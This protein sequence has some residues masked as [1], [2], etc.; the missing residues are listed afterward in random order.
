MRI[1]VLGLGNDLLAD[2]GFGLIAARSLAGDTSPGVEV[3]CSAA[4]GLA[5][6]DALEGATHVLVLDTWPR[7]GKPGT[8]Y[9]AELGL[10][11]ARG[12]EPRGSSTRPEQELRPAPEIV[13]PRGTSLHYVGLLDA[14]ALGRCLGLPV[15][16]R[17]ACVG[18][19]PGD[20]ETVGGAMTEA[21]RMALP[22]ALRRAR[23]IIE[24]WSRV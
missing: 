17:V 1:R 10:S 21:V 9:S 7:N 14:L 4:A 13:L 24:A 11:P 16:S 18:V 3:A 23:Q 5:L 12:S 6:L 8:V 20:C 22:E 19:E 15:P 2:D